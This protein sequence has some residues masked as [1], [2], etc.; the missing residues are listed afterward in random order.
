M[1]AIG[2]I[3]GDR[4]P[5]GRRVGSAWSSRFCDIPLRVSL[6]SSL[7][8]IHLHVHHNDPILFSFPSVFV[9]LKARLLLL[10]VLNECRVFFFGFSFFFSLL[11]FSSAIPFP[12]LLVAM[13]AAARQPA[14]IAARAATLAA[15][16]CAVP[17]PTHAI[18]GATVGR[19]ASARCSSQVSP[20]PS[21]VACSCN[22]HSPNSHKD[23]CLNNNRWMC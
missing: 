4:G 14:V 5:E 19:I 16:L 7:R 17:A 15:R 18:A 12:S 20:I 11:F 3:D 22:A 1:D 9:R 23:E 13:H 10:D 8:L 6:I 21:A 2:S